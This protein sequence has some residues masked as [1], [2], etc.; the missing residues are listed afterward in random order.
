MNGERKNIS[1]FAIASLVIGVA[2]FINL[3]GLEKAIIAV[4]FGLLALKEMEKNSELGG[5]NFAYAGLAIGGLAAVV[6][7]V[8]IVKFLPQIKAQLEQQKGE[9]AIEST[10]VIPGTKLY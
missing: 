6:A 4:I 1:A 8:L 3:A 2:A 7:I 9:T 10:D 5:K